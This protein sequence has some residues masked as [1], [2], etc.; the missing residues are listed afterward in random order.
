MDFQLLPNVE[1][2]KKK[3]NKTANYYKLS[4]NSEGYSP[5]LYKLSVSSSG[6]VKAE[7]LVEKQSIEKKKNRTTYTHMPREMEIQA[8]KNSHMREP[9]LGSARQH[10][11]CRCLMKGSQVITVP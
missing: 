6:K 4:S 7:K 1:R 11:V 8:G 2:K 9:S 5:R 10:N 3:K